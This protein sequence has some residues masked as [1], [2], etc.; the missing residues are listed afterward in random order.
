MNNC[1]CDDIK[2]YAVRIEYHYKNNDHE[3]KPNSGSGVI[4]KP[5]NNSKICY[6][7]TAKHI[8]KKSENSVVRKEEINCDDIYI[9]EHN[10]NKLVCDS[11]EVNAAHDLVILFLNIE[12]N[13]LTIEPISILNDDKFKYGIIA[14]YPNIRNEEDSKFDCYKCT[15]DKINDDIDK[16][17]FEVQ[18]DKPLESLENTGYDN[19]KG[20]SGSGVFTKGTECKYY[21]VGIQLAIVNIILLS[22]LD[23]R[24]II[25]EVNKHLPEKIGLEGYS[26]SEAIGVEP[27]SLDFYWIK[28]EL[29]ND[30]ISKIKNKE[31]AEQLEYIKDNHNKFNRDLKKL[32]KEIESKSKTIADTY[33]YKSIIF[34]EYNENQ[35]ATNN[36]KKAVKLEPSYDTYFATAKLERER[37]TKNRA[38]N[39]KGLPI[40]DE[41]SLEQSEKRYKSALEVEE[42]NISKLKL[43]YN[44]QSITSKKL[45][46]VSN[47]QEKQKVYDD[48]IKAYLSIL[49]IYSKN[50]NNT[51]HHFEKAKI[52]CVLGKL[53]I[54]KEKYEIAKKFLQESLQESLKL[55][56]N[57]TALK[58][59][60]YRNLAY[61]SAK[62]SLFKEAV[63]YYRNALKLYRHL[64][65]KN[66]AYT[67]EIISTLNDLAVVTDKLDKEDVIDVR[68]YYDEA[69]DNLKL[70]D[71][72]SE[73]CR[74]LRIR[75]ENNLK[76]HR[77]NLSDSIQIKKLTDE[78]VNQHHLLNN[79]LRVVSS[80]SKENLKS[81]EKRLENDRVND[82]TETASIIKIHLDN[83]EKK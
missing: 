20:L 27:T 33:L 41:K 1:E 47:K 50:E 31:L 15:H 19:I 64:Q 23:L 17:L 53:H 77:K 66:N 45:T 26:F 32:H 14:G 5:N 42:D 65:K 16:Y 25:E 54:K 22:C 24:E 7:L 13:Q 76:K 79:I 40:P 55:S 29:K 35:R 57:H 61:I 44:L 63:K 72:D 21:L 59:S 12:E 37:R 46:L 78:V 83:K 2:Q 75:T 43:L 3:N 30:F 70:L 62:Q 58:A 39:T 36:F 52:L 49:S 73:I 34:H 18:S 11:L 38:Q 80:L 8:F 10:G 28:G 82:L 51:S 9:Y 81:G 69:F 56:S 48:L 68:R 71:K 4:V 60:A 6:I 67:K 74:Q